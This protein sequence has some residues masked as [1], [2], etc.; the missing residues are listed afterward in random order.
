MSRNFTRYVILGGDGAFG[1]HM[2]RFLLGSGETERVVSVGRNQRKP[3]HYSLGVGEGDQ[4]FR[5]FQAHMVHEQDILLRLLDE[6]QPE[7]IINFAALAYATSWSDSFRY[8]ETNVVAL[9]R[10]IET[11]RTRPYLRHWMQVGSA[12]VYGSAN[13]GPSL[14]DGAIHPTSPYAVSKLAAD[15]HLMTYVRDTFAINIIRPSKTYGPAQPM[16]R[17]MPKAAFCALAGR[18]FPLE[19][20]GVVRKSWLHVADMVAAIHRIVIDGQDRQIYNAGPNEAIPIHDVVRLIAENVGIEFENFV[21]LAP[22]RPVEDDLYLLD[23]SK[24]RDE[25][26]WSPTIDLQSGIGGV[27]DWVRENLDALSREPQTF[28]LRS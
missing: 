20:A 8:Y 22:G 27:V 14:E 6:E 12:E 17:L 2:A 26:E 4:R 13:S 3:P 5:Y 23:S 28:S 9:A 1:T 10:L 7:C 11:L 18:R 19:G 21:D 16:Y 15:M 25:L 24:I